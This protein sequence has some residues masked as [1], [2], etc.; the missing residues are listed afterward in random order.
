[1]NNHVSLW[2]YNR[3]DE[4]IR[5]HS[6]RERIFSEEAYVNDVRRAM[7]RARNYLNA[8]YSK[9]VNK[10][11]RLFKEISEVLDLMQKQEKVHIL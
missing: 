3:L 11:R 6:F 1:M 9:N 5:N 8:C 4:L 7:T 10:S 2:C